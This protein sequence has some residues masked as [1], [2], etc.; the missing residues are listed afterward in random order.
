ML[1]SSLKTLSC[2]EDH[3][4]LASDMGVSSTIERNKMHTICKVNTVATHPVAIK[5]IPTDRTG[6][7]HTHRRGLAQTAATV[8]T[9]AN[10]AEAA[11]PRPNRLRR[12]GTSHPILLRL[13]MLYRVI[14]L[15][16]V[17]GSMCQ[18]ISVLTTHQLTLWERCL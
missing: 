12:V 2:T 4:V 3:S 7:Y 1:K 10:T 15:P 17:T 18:R 6:R 11:I 9:P 5:V 13:I 16:R 8:L 14:A